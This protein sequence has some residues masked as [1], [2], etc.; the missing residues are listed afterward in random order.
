MSNFTLRIWNIL[1]AAQQSST[2]TPTVFSYELISNCYFEICSLYSC[3]FFNPETLL[4]NS[5]NK[6]K[7]L[8]GMIEQVCF[9]TSSSSALNDETG[10]HATTIRLKFIN[11][12]MKEQRLFEMCDKSMNSFQQKLVSFLIYAYLNNSSIG[13]SSTTSGGVQTTTSYIN[14]VDAELNVFLTSSVDK[15]SIFNELQLR[16][17]DL[18]IENFLTEFIKKY[19]ARL[20][21]ITVNIFYTILLEFDHFFSKKKLSSHLLIKKMKSKNSQFIFKT[22]SNLSTQCRRYPHMRLFTSATC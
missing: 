13:E 11:H 6:M 21:Q 4:V 12:I 22:L 5:S 19:A 8:L 18:N 20:K 7:T 17:R 15:I 1:L 14:L 3:L 16:N 10:G 2:H 9:A